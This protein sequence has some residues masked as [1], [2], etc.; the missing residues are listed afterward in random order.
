[1]IAPF[2]FS[3]LPRIIFGRGTISELPALTGSFGKNVLLIT[4]I[5]SFNTSSAFEKFKETL[6]L[7]KAKF[8]HVSFSGEPTPQIVDEIYQE[9]SAKSIHVVVS[10][11]GGSVIDAGKAVSAMMAETGSVTDFLEGIG[12]KKI[13]GCKAPF[14]AVPTTAGT[15]SE[16][17]KNAVLS[18]VGEQGYKKSLRHDNFVPDVA[19][20]DPELALTCP[21]EITAAC[22]LDAISQLIESFT[23]TKSNP[24]TDSLAINGLFF[25]FNSFKPLMKGSLDDVRMRE[26]MAYSSLVSG[27]T[28]AQAGLGTVHGIAGPLGGFFHIPH[29]VA[30]GSLLPGVM[31]RIVAALKKTDEKAIVGKIA[32]IGRVIENHPDKSDI[33]HCDLVVETLEEYIELSGLSR[34]GFYGISAEHIEKIVDASDNKNS[35]VQFSKEEMIDIIR[36]RL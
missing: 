19:L 32:K 31:K 18:I 3:G 20:I 11:G 15:G 35:P 26:M 23:S 10:I 8:Y 4:G 16:A 28:L 14:I 27:I 17:T 29:G 30:C 34:L 24:I 22:G 12:T 13:S 33:Y 25:A 6:N 9:Y 36:E 7:K 21:K 5:K 2:T 1:M